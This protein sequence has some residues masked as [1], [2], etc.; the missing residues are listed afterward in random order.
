MGNIIDY[1]ERYCSKTFY[2]VPFKREDAICL[3]QLSYLKFDELVPSMSSHEVL[4]SDLKDREGFDTLFSDV[5]YETKNRELYAAFV[6]S[7]RFNDLKLSFYINRIDTEDESQ[8]SAITFTLPG[9]NI[10]ITFRGTDETMIGWHEDVDMALHEAVPGQK[11]SVE[12]LNNVSKSVHGPFMVGG[13]SKGG[14]LAMYASMCCDDKARDRISKI[15][16]LD[17]PGFRSSF[18]TE[19]NYNEIKDRVERII[20]KSSYVGLI[21]ASDKD[22]MVVDSRYLGFSQHILYN[23][24]IERGRLKEA[25]LSKRHI[26]TLKAFNDTV[27]SLNEE[28]TVMFVQCLKD[29][30]DSFDADTTIELKEDISKHLYAALKSQ[31]KIDEDTKKLME[32]FVRTYLELL[33]NTKTRG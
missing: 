5:R 19:H 8:F 6:K 31:K 2:D 25:K 22:H 29:F 33:I 14:N 12:Y 21:F 20:P 27:L 9:G 11:L 32:D 16:C 13:H 26:R 24:V 3:A 28:E 23:W 18:L 15:Y 4:L 30:M 10:F 7:V 17:G 1:L